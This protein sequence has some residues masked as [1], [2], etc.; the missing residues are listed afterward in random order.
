LKYREI[1]AADVP[2]LFYVRTRTRE[3]AYT[4]EQLQHV[5]ITAESVADK[6]AT[7]FKGWLG[8]DGDHVVGFCIADRSTGELWVIAVLPQY[9]GKGIGNQLMSFA[10]EWLSA[11]GCNRAWLTTDVDTK[12]RA[13]GFY[14]QRG[15]ADWKLENGLRWMELY[16]SKAAIQD[17]R[18]S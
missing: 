11:S 7:S 8:T 14:R 2:E 6:L 17:S 12:L 3:N 16:P 10:E 13:Y 15:W 9:E 4:H 5:G 1:T 18:R